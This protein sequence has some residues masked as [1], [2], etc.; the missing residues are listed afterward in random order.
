MGALDAQ[1]TTQSIE[2]K[3]MAI[4]K[5]WLIA[6]GR[7]P[8]KSDNKTFD[9][10]VD[11]KYAELKAKKHGWSKFDFI[12]LTENQVKELGK[13]LELIFVVLNVD[14]TDLNNIDPAN[15]LEIPAEALLNHLKEPK[16]V[17]TIIHYEWNKGILDEWRR[18]LS[19]TPRS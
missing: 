11:G 2:K 9:L 18:S 10:R 14:E 19:D 1:E 12:G 3:G 6:N 16:K 13:G 15:I 8:E 5:Q 7:T 17:K 4:L